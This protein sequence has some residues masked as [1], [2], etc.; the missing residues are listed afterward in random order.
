MAG[1]RGVGTVALEGFLSRRIMSPKVYTWEE[2]SGNIMLL[3]EGESIGREKGR[4]LLKQCS[5]KWGP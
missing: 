5:K 4:R 2:K 3:K 1:H